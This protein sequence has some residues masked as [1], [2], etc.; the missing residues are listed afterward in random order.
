MVSV[1]IDWTLLAQLVTFLVL[2]FILNEILFKPIQAILKERARVFEDLKDR[3]QKSKDSLAE[4][5]AKEESSKAEALRSGNEALK[6]LR[7]EGKAKEKEILDKAQA[8][9]A[10]KMEAAQKS[11]ESEVAQAKGDLE[12]QAKALGSQIASKLL[13]REI[14]VE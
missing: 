3:A 6:A 7:S 13:G 1:A 5:E 2:M 14:S 8:E 9:A 12:L 11:L 4:G 10:K